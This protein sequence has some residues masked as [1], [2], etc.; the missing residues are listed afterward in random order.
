MLTRK[1]GKLV[2]R[3]TIANAIWSRPATA[4]KNLL[5]V[6]MSSLRKEVD[7]KGVP[8]YVETVRGEGFRLID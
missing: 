6:H 3:S 8:A 4:A 1:P 5:D 2:S 7:S